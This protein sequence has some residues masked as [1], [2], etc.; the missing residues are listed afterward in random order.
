M[1]EE[2]ESRG[3]KLVIDTYN[4]ASYDVGSCTCTGVVE[5]TSN[6]TSNME[7]TTLGSL[8]PDDRQCG[9]NIQIIKG[10]STTTSSCFISESQT[11]ANGD[12]VTIKWNKMRDSRDSKY[13]LYL[14]FDESGKDLY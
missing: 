8:H 9:S 10:N 4:S 7:L 12:K 3:S 2:S 14:I 6:P 11:V 1:C 5:S 13:C